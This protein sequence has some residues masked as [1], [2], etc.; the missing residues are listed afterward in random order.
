MIMKYALVTGS[1]KGIGLSIGIGLLETG[2]FVFFNNPPNDRDFNEFNQKI[3]ED[4][5]DKYTFIEADVSN[6]DCINK[7]Y[8]EVLIKT[9]HI[10][11]FIFNAGIT[12]RSPLQDITYESWIKI[13]NIFVNVPVFILQKFYPILNRNS[14]IVFIGSMLGDIPHSTSLSYGVSKAGIHA[15][16][17]NLVK[18]FADKKVRVNGVSPGFI[19][20]YWQLRKDPEIRKRIENKIALKM[21]GRPDN[22][23]DLVL[24]IISN[25]YINGSI[26]RID[27]GYSY[28]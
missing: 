26:L 3:C 25:D 19:D 20:T 12:D 8:D 6:I 1:T 13:Q 11:L 9:K 18:F 28:E 7:I 2:Y 14:N 22:V 23:R 5:N 10:D 16:V 15:L 4:Y 17:R 21:F 27:G 24:H